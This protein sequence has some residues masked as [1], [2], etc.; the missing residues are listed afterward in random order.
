MS[1]AKNGLFAFQ[2]PIKQLYWLKNPNLSWIY[3]YQL[4]LMLTALFH[5]DLISLSLHV[6]Q[7]I[8]MFHFLNDIVND[9]DSTLHHNP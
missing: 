1:M 2:H 7:V 9:V 4:P 5:I 3:I 6:Y 8:M